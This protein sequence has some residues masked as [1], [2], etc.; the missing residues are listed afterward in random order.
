MQAD[1]NQKELEDTYSSPWSLMGTQ[2]CTP[3]TSLQSAYS[4]LYMIFNDTRERKVE[5]MADYF[6]IGRGPFLGMVHPA[7]LGVTF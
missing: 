5:D 4:R 2:G 1:T 3:L 6:G 7:I